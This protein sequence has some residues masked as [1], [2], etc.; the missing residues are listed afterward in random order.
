MYSKFY[1]EQIS[2]VGI[3]PDVKEV[4]DRLSD[5]SIKLAIASQTP[6][7][8]LSKI[9]KGSSIGNKFEIVLGMRD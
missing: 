1:I 6:K 2:E 7:E 3:F 8:A 5:M 4:I 9:L